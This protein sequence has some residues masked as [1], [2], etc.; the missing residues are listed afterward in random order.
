MPVKTDSILKI[1]NISLS[2]GGVKALTNVS[3]NVHEGEILSII[4]PNGA[5]KTCVINCINRFYKPQTGSISFKGR[6][7]TRLHS[8]QVARSGIA[9][10]FQNIGLLGYLSVIENLIAGRHCFMS[11]GFRGATFGSIY[12]GKAQHEEAE[13]RRIAEEIIEFLQIGNIKNSLV[14]TLPYGLR[15]RVELG[16]ALMLNPE[17]LILD[18]PLTGMNLDEKKDMVGFIL[19]IHK[20]RVHTIILIEHDMGVVMDISHRIIVLDFGKKIAEGTPDQVKTDPLV[21]EAYLGGAVD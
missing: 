8:Y 15:K 9:R 10:T 3:I 4:G 6:E 7:L 20:N 18:E 11:S 2:F 14:G 13:S 17:I 21:I 16:R 1:D 12:I 19:D 5:G